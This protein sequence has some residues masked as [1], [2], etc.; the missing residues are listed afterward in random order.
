MKY[1]INCLG[2]TYQYSKKQ[3]WLCFW[4]STVELEVR[5]GTM[6]AIR[7]QERHAAGE[8]DDQGSVM[9]EDLREFDA[10]YQIIWDP[11]PG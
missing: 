11:M 6:S 4:H 2:F 8:D 10:E 9:S 5:R 3:T 7:R 1:K